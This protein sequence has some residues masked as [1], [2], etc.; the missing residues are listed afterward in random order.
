M[1]RGSFPGAIRWRRTACRESS[2]RR[3]GREP[4]FGRGRN[5]LALARL[6][7]FRGIVEAGARFHLDEDQQLAPARH[8]IDFAGRA[9]PAPR[10]D[11]ITLGDEIGGGAAFRRK[12]E[13]KCRDAFRARRFCRVYRLSAARHCRLFRKFE[14]ALIDLA[15]RRGRSRRHFAD[16]VLHRDAGQRMAQQRVD[17]FGSARSLSGGAMT[18]TISPRVSAPFGIVARQ[19]RE[20]RC[21]ELLRAAWSVRGRPRPRAVPDRRRD[22]RAPRR[23]AG[24]FRT[25]SALPECARARRCAFAAPLPSAAGSPRRR[26][27]RSARPATESAVST[28]EAPGSAV[29]AWPPARASRTSL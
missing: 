14:R 25:G 16:R 17:V 11:A 27:G 26:T 13:A 6:D 7:R 15:A 12:A 29:T 9:F 20:D 28:A 23:A 1:W 10:Q 22:R 4:G 18:M 2:D 21:A 24:R 8:D 3:I 5:A 19:L